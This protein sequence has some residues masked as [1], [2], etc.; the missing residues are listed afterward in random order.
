MN[1]QICLLILLFVPNVH[2]K[3]W[4]TACPSWRISRSSCRTHGPQ[5]LLQVTDINMKIQN[6]KVVLFK[7]SGIQDILSFFVSIYYRCCPAT[8]AKDQRRVFKLWVTK[9]NSM[10][11]HTISAQLYFFSCFVLLS[12]CLPLSL[13]VNSAYKYLSLSEENWRVN[14]EFNER[15]YFVH[16]D[17]FTN[18]GQVLCREGLSKRCYWEVGQ[19]TVLYL[20]CGSVIQRHQQN[21]IGLRVWKE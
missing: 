17:K 12:D 13:D 4:L 16:S 19:S 1:L 21:I 11:F 5:C 20:V 15:F 2:S 14:R 8:C 7:S 9:I 6:Y 10:P 3:L 18:V